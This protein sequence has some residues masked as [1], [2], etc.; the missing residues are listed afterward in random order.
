MALRYPERLA[1]ATLRPMQFSLLLFRPLIALFNGAA[2]A[3]LRAAKMDVQHSHA[4]VHSPRSCR[5]CTVK[6]PTAA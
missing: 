5:T 4:H 1:L 6:A 3:L 2:F